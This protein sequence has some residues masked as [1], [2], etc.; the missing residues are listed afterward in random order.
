MEDK[1][2]GK[3][4]E[5]SAEEK[6]FKVTVTV[7]TKAMEEFI[8]EESFT[9]KEIF[10]YAD[11]IYESYQEYLPRLNKE[12]LRPDY[13]EFATVIKNADQKLA[14][15]ISSL[16]KAFVNDKYV[17]S[18]DQINAWEVAIDRIENEIIPRMEEEGLYLS[19]K[20]LRG[21]IIQAEIK[22]ANDD[23]GSE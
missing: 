18:E 15:C 10:E 13:D 20:L 14:T 3:P 21:A 9:I 7:R 2:K 6:L 5:L 8:D 19:T 17:L 23:S 11:F 4:N 1:P 16:F 22:I 12:N